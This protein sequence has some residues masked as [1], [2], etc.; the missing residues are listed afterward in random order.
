MAVET[1]LVVEDESSI[2]QL[3]TT[4]LSDHGWHCLAAKNAQEALVHL[5]NNSIDLAIIDWML[6][7][8]SGIELIKK[9]RHDELTRALPVIML[10]AR[11]EEYDKIT[12]LD[13]GADDFIVK[14]FSPRELASRTRALLRRSSGFNSR[15]WLSHQH[16]KIDIAAQQVSTESEVIPL[17]Q[18]EYK[19]LVFLMK[20]PDR[21]YSR[22][23][24]LD[25]IWGQNS[26]IDERTVD[27]HILRLRKALRPHTA[28][29][30]LQTVR[31]S[32]YRFS[33]L[34]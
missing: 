28:D 22:N 25:H 21:V 31:G 30:F 9:L 14:P 8:T 2:R 5:A 3:I 34:V 20:H 33:T 29:K 7:T 1:I 23:Q 18:T 32:G 13:A 26:F 19:L 24:L 27:V 10:T 6:P 12:G 17:G 15:E 16:L 4:S 11:G